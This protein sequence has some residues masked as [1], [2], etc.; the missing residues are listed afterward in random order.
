MENN[1]R[2][3]IPNEEVQLNSEDKIRIAKSMILLFLFSTMIVSSM[4]YYSAPS[5]NP[6]LVFEGPH[7]NNVK[8]DK[9]VHNFPV[10]K[11][12]SRY[13]IGNRIELNIVLE[14]IG[15]T[16]NINSD[17]YRSIKMQVKFSKNKA[18]IKIFENESKELDA[19][20]FEVPSNF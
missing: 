20:P 1:N 7:N 16:N 14:R 3:I 6:N 18:R 12:N 9:H 17:Y 10:Y 19:K 5:I 13:M 2:T 4:A 11:L 15:R 8:H